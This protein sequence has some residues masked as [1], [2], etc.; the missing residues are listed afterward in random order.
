M[1]TCWEFNLLI[2]FNRAINTKDE[3]M[4]QLLR[5]IQQVPKDVIYFLLSNFI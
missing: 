4:K 2:W 3:G 1:M 5:K